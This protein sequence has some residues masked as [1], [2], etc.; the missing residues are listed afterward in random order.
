M[1]AITHWSSL[2]ADS[3]GD[4][5]IDGTACSIAGS[6]RVVVLI[7]GVGLD[8]TL[9]VR[10]AAD[11]SRDYCVIRHDM[12][13]HGGSGQVNDGATLE[14]FADQLARLL[15]DLGVHRAAIAGFSLGALVTQ[16]FVRRYPERVAKMALLHSVY[17]RDAAARAAVQ[18]R[19]EQAK[20]DGTQSLID[21]ALKRWFSEA[22]R[23]ANPAI[24]AAIRQRLSNNDPTQF[25]LA[26]KLFASADIPM[27]GVVD[28][29]NTPTLVMTGERDTGSTPAMSK[30]LAAD[31]P[32]S[33]LV[34]LPGQRHLGIIE[35][36]ADTIDHLRRWLRM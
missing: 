8:R 22:F 6:G 3:S 14:D 33:T 31:I 35:A 27:V 5:I 18:F 36:A 21:D 1:N 23:T 17:R 11:L 24:E 2:G 30:A 15:D 32:G 13:G 4:H 25:L 26:Y 10:H 34:V 29:A 20:R 16:V 9:W 7:H 12:P 19:V 28:G